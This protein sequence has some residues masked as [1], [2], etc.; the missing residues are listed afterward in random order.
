MTTHTFNI[1]DRVVFRNP[2]Y[3]ESTGTV[4]SIYKGSSGNILFQYDEPNPSF[5]ENNNRYYCFSPEDVF[6]LGPPKTKT[7]IICDKIQYLYNK[8]QKCL[9]KRLS[10]R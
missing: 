6:P 10:M 2:E 4:V 1:G 9:D 7:E 3:P 8:H 5:G